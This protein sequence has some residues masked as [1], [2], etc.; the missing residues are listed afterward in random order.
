MSEYN[1]SVEYIKGAT[2]TAA[3]ALS[4]LIKMLDEAWRPLRLEDQDSD[5][6]YPFLLLWPEV[7]LLSVASQFD[8]ARTAPY[9]FDMSAVSDSI[10]KLFEQE[11]RLNNPLHEI[12][13]HERILLVEQGFHWRFKVQN[14]SADL[15]S[16]CM[17]SNSV[18]V[19]KDQQVSENSESRT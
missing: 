9:K 1:Y 15:Y 2:N 3:D 4:R 5:E 11:D 18:Q 6:N 16:A 19:L 12:Y 13:N 7:H 14:I 8:P 10:A 17:I